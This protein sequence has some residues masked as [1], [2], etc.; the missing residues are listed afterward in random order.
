MNIYVSLTTIPFRVKKLY[1]TL[2][3]I[4]RQSVKPTKIFL[5]IPRKYA[6]FPDETISEED[7][8]KLQA[9]YQDMLQINRIDVDYGP[10]TKLVGAIPHINFEDDGLLILVDDD[11][12]YKPY[13]IKGFIEQYDINLENTRCYSY[14][15]YDIDMGYSSLTIGQGVDGFAIPFKCLR[16]FNNYISRFNFYQLTTDCELWYIFLH[17]DLWISYFLYLNNYNIQ[18]INET[19]NTVYLMLDKYSDNANLSLCSIIGKYNREN[20]CKIGIEILQRLTYTSIYSCFE[21]NIKTYFVEDITNKIFIEG[22]NFSMFKSICYDEVDKTNYYYAERLCINNVNGLKTGKR[23]EQGYQLVGFDIEA[24]DPRLIFLNGKVYI[25]FIC[26]SKHSDRSIAITEFNTWK[27]TCLRLRNTPCNP[28]E[29]NWAPYVKN[30]T[31]YFVYNYDPLI[32]I[33]YDFNSD[34][35][36]DVVYRQQNTLLPCQTAETIIRGGSNL[37]PY[38][39]NIY[40]GG[41]HDRIF[42]IDKFVHFTRIVLLD[43]ETFQI[44]YVSKPIAYVYPHYNLNKIKNTEI[45]YHSETN[46]IQD[47]I[48]INKV[49]N[50]YYLTIN[51]CDCK[52]LLYELSIDIKPEKYTSYNN[53]GDIQRKVEYDMNCILNFMNF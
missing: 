25:I 2:N 9:Q 6:R 27:P 39:D 20:C 43:T 44:K 29:K 7:I 13:M 38:S 30:N 8:E 48:S 18:N 53:I 10:G 3:S 34:G 22:L 5:N 52:T 19:L 32:I 1:I 17:D 41:C 24:E 46:L 50:R 15:T 31:L 42:H 36:C 14:Y 23:N 45:M 47:P 16:K 33:R 12:I 4:I 49:D 51:V 37:I 35:L 26:I 21:D 11:V 28:I 40:I